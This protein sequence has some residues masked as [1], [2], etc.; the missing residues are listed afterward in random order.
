MKTGNF[1]AA[2][3]ALLTVPELVHWLALCPSRLVCDALE[4]TTWVQFA[5]FQAQQARAT[6]HIVT[7]KVHSRKYIYAI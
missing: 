1:R 4:I 2:N 6:S 5:R 7:E 3:P